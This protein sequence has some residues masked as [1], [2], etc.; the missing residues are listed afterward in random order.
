MGEA[1]WIEH[2]LALPHEQPDAWMVESREIGGCALRLMRPRS[3]DQLLDDPGVRRASVDFDYMPYW[4]FL[5]PGALLLAEHVLSERP[6]PVGRA[7]EIGCGLGLAGLA[8]LAVGWHVTFS[9]YSPAAL[10]IAAMNA[11]LNGFDRF[12][13]RIIDWQDPPADSFELVLGADVLYEARCVPDVLRVLNRMLSP[14]GVALLADPGR[15][16]AD[17]FPAVAA[18]AG[19]RVWTEAVS[20]RNELGIVTMGRTFR[21][22]CGEASTGTA[23]THSSRR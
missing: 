10:E 16:V 23:P 20:S 2:G 19:Y 5:W 14:G 13:T 15:S 6:A 9:D 17:P 3:P 8:A 11:R 22:V 7:I 18:G 12:E 4:A 1:T 21:C